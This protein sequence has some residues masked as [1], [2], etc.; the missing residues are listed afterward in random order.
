MG[1]YFFDQYSLLHFATGVVSYFWGFGFVETVIFHIL[2]EI[3]ENSPI[4]VYIINKYFKNWP[5]KKMF[6]DSIINSVGDTIA[7]AAGW[8]AGFY[9][10][11]I[12]TK[13]G[14]YTGPHRLH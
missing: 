5:G 3:V 11:Q 13:Y 1:V 9:L 8:L 4:G 10:D 12:G 6:R 14:W 7:N 2:F